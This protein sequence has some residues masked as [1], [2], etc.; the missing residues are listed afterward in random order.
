MLVYNLKL[1]PYWREFRKNMTDAERRVWSKLRLKQLEGCQF[2]RQ[3]II[4]EYIV[5]FYCPKAKI[6]IEVDGSQHF[7]DGMVEADKARDKYILNRGLKVLRFT[8]T[9]VLKNIDGVTGKILENLK[10][11]E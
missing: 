3:R 6:V 1:K 8:D 4:G 11:P 10:G 5:D 2:Y 9:E 7:S